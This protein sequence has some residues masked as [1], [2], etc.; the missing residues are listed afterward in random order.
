MFR[1][2]L[3]YEAHEAQYKAVVKEILGDDE[4]EEEEEGGEAGAGQ[5]SC[6]WFSCFCCLNVFCLVRLVESVCAGTSNLTRVPDVAVQPSC[7]ACR[8]HLS[9]HVL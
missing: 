4:E 7:S 6:S 1:E 5:S 3:E 9:H 8:C 2:D